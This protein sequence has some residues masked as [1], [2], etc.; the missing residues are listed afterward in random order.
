V[1]KWKII[2]ALVAV[3]ALAVTVVGLAAAQTTTPNPTTGT[4]AGVWG[5]IGSC[6][7]FRTTPPT[8]GTQVQTPTVPAQP[9]TTAPATPNQGGYYAS[10]YGPCWARW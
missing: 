3:A 1:R 6:F 4:N 7:R 8:A 10:G 2:L 5:W 9:S